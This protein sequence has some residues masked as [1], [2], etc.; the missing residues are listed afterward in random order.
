MNYI[1]KGRSPFKKTVKKGDIVH[2]GRGGVNPSSFLKPKFTGFSNHSEMDFWHHNMSLKSLRNGLLTP[3]YES[4]WV[5][6]HHNMSQYESQITQKWTFDT[7]IW[8]ASPI[9]ALLSVIRQQMSPFDPFRGG[10]RQKGTMSPFFTVFFF[11]RASLSF[12]WKMLLFLRKL[13]Y[14]I[15]LWKKH[16]QTREIEKR[17][18]FLWK[19]FYIEH[20]IE[21]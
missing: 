5:F 1:S 3:Q 21:T 14:Q 9:Y 15:I 19:Q 16:Y 18:C 8:V 13:N 2:T 10:G 12:Y 7:T 6:W 20:K 17:F 4:I 11:R